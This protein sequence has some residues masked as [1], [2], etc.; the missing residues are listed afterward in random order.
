M[1]PAAACA[2]AVS[3]FSCAGGPPRPAT[4]DTH[5]DACAACRMAVSNPRFAAQVVAPGEEPIFFDDIG[6]LADYL[7]QHGPQPARAIAYVADH[8][9]SE[10]VA[11]AAAI[12]TR[13]AG[14]DTPMGSHVIAHASPSSRDADTAARGGTDVSPAA[15]FPT[16]IPDGTR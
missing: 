9:T 2:L 8:R 1:R 10:W 14:L 7:R 11:A 13:V 5:N 16:P 4:L 6:C 3:L 12:F 15:L